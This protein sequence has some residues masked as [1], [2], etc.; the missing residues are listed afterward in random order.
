MIKKPKL[1]ITMGCSYTEGVGCWDLS[2]IPEGMTNSDVWHEKYLQ[3][4]QK[5]LKNFHEKGW[6]NKLCK[7]LGYDEVLNLG[8][9]G[10]STSGQMKSFIEKYEKN[11]FSEYDVL[12]VW[13]LTEP[14]RFSF[15]KNGSINNILPNEKYNSDNNIGPAYINFIDDVVLDPILEQIFYIKSFI[16]ICENRG[17]GLIITYWEENSGNHLLNQFK[18]PYF[19]YNHPHNL[20]PPWPYEKPYGSSLCLHPNENGYEFLADKIYQGIEKNH[21]HFIP[22]IKSESFEWNWGGK[23]TQHEIYFKKNHSQ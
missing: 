12:V 23:N 21:S 5:N 11:S 14:S 2:T 6:P 3:V 18:S 15:Y 9:A 4:Y 10:S 7:K 8:L 20:L 1:L 19:L 22:E 13:L 17:Y 16:D